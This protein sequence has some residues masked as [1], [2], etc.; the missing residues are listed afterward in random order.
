MEFNSAVTTTTRSMIVPKV[1]DTISKG[2]PIL[3]KLLQTAK[4]WKT[5]TAYKFPIKYQDS[6][7]GGN[8]GVA[9]KLDTDR[10]DVRVTASF[11][12]KMA[13]K[14]VVVANIELVLNQGDE[15]IVDLLTTEFDSQ[16]QSLMQ[17]M[18]GNVYT[19]T[20]S[21]DSW[22]SIDNAAD[23]GTNYGTYGS[24][25]RT[26][27][28]S[29]K[30]Y[31]LA[32]AGAMTLAK[33]ATGYDAVEIG[34]DA[35]DIMA[36]TKALWSVYESLLTPTVRAGYVQNG[37]PRMNAFGM[38]PTTQALAGQQGFD[39]LWFRGTPMVKDEQCPSGK[40]YFMNTNYFG[41]KGID[42]SVGQKNISTVNFKKTTDGVPAGVPGRIPSTRGFN[43]RDLMSPTDQLAEVGH[44]IYA[45]NFI[46][47]NPR[48]QG[49]IRGLS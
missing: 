8:T 23:D 48:L 34:T 19:G 33:L 16:A 44:I 31:Y 29:I 47:E 49:Q 7:N 24:L 15:K 38:L 27:Y 28:T 40:L 32:S 41:M 45:G 18:G 37:F 22:D 10:Q 13:Y 4:S 1:F 3:M 12:P 35:P 17:L 11:Q 43:F 14:P 21:G 46:S 36:T 25:S 5:G 2:S 30:G 20:G 6:T 9:N 39:A 42:M 26:T